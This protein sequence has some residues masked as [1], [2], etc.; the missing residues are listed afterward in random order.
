M[1][2]L[3]AQLRV[4]L[5]LLLAGALLRLIGLGA[6]S[7]WLDEGATWAW[8]TRADW[9]GPDGTI[10]AEANH[11]PV[12]WIITRLWIDGF[13]S[14]TEMALRAPA[15]LCGILTIPAA[16]LLGRRLLDPTQ[17]PSRGGFEHEA[18]GG[19]GARLALWF[20]G[21]I[22]LSTYFTEYSQEARMYALL[23]LEALGLSL[24]YLRWLDK[25]DK[26]SLVGYALVAALA[27]HTQ[28]FALWVICG[29]GVHALWLWRRGAKEGTAFNPLPFVLACAAAGLLFVP[30]FLHMTANYESISTGDS[31]EPFGRLFYVLWRIGVGPGL[32]VVDRGRLEQGISEVVEEEALIAGVTI[33]LW[34]VPLVLG[35]LRLRKL[36]GIASF[37]WCNLLVP[38]ALL[39]L[40]FPKF[41]LIHERYVVFLAPWLFLLA[42]LGALQARGLFKPLLVGG[43]LALTL[44]GLFTFHG[45]STQLVPEG[46]MQTLGDASVPS[47]FAPDPLDPAAVLNHGHPFGKEPWRQAHA[48]VAAHAGPR[49]L[50]VLHPPYLRLVWDYYEREAHETAYLP[51][52]TADAAALEPVLGPRLENRTRV[53]LVLAHE[54]T[55]DPDHYF[56]VLQRLILKAWVEDGGGRVDPPVRPILFDTSWGVRVGVFN[57][58]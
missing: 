42:V 15:A 11:P 43:L 30:W 40:I 35:A 36:P 16:W 8:A 1:R 58:R 4:L 22:A 9:W 23:I 6:H 18:D 53:F 5:N 10:L 56:K 19:R 7:L 48:F 34:F 21:F 57:R 32:V 17:R 12:W 14:D 28:Y 50:I 13:G 33:V 54:E 49:D 46:P 39:L 25:N 47:R 44:A 51:R 26:L 41:Q 38:I 52:G 55:E 31:Y 29:H 20:T 24:L 2:S 37:V 27:L 45:V 3:T